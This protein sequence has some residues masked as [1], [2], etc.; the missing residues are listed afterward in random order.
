[1]E[2]RERERES[3]AERGQDSK[4]G[5]D[6]SMFGWECMYEPRKRERERDQR[7]QE[8]LYIIITN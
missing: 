6:V 1:M 8:T 7:I 2:H 4:E 5:R 3:R